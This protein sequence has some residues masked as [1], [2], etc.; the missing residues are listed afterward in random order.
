[1]HAP[2]IAMLVHVAL[3]QQCW[4]YCELTGLTAICMLA[5]EV[6]EQQS[7][8][9]MINVLVRTARCLCARVHMVTPILP[10]AYGCPASP[11]SSCR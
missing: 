11:A 8:T 1:M 6:I 10:M 9:Q 7:S 3:M 4:Q 5:G 2:C